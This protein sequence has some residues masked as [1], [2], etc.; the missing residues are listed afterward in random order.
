M[1]KRLVYFNGVFVAEKDAKVSIYDSALMFGD[2]VFEMTR[3]FNQVQFKLKDHLDRLYRGIKILN[4]PVNLSIEEMEQK[5]L[6]TIEINKPFFD[7][8]DEHRLL[9]N[10]SR[11]PLGIYAPIFDNK[12]EPTIIISDF[13]LKFTVSSLARFFDTGINLVIPSQRAIPATLMDPK[14][15]NR[16]RMWYQMANLE[17]SKVEGDNN[18]A[19]LIDPD[20]Y[21]AEGTG[22]NFFMIKDGVIITPESRNI[23][24]GVSREYIFELAKELN[25]PCIEKNIEPYDVYDADEAFV[26]ATPFCML[27]VASLNSYKI[28]NK[29]QINITKKLIDQWSDNVG[30]DIVGQIKNYHIE[31]GGLKTSAPTPY[32]FKNKLD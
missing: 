15:K 3:S 28:N 10:V 26:C 22:D 13:P 1:S 2:M 11:G 5:C 20:G 31:L 32:Q 24:R 17:V 23:L 6:E 8:T 30:V 9:I 25:I 7:S 12:I 29:H 27:P 4:I 14:I 16:S 19:L 18:W 21:I